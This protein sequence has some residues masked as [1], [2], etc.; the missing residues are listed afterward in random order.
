LLPVPLKL[1]FSGLLLALE[2]TVIAPDTVAAV[3]G[4]KFT[5]TAQEPAAGR[6]VPQLFDWE[7]VV[8]EP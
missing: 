4:V 8:G 3:A 2:V 6:L 1:I 5:V 7:N